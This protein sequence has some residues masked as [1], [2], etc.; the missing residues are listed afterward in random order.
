M[1]H[2]EYLSTVADRSAT[3]QAQQKLLH[4]MSG[5]V[6]VVALGLVL[7]YRLS[8]ISRRLK[9]GNGNYYLTGKLIQIIKKQPVIIRG[10]I[11][12]FHLNASFCSSPWL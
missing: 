9:K 3:T 6:V 7:N 10:P 1:P 5:W 4:Q 12:S 2:L 11:V 8:I